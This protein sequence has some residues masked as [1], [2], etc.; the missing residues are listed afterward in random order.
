MIQ[1]KSGMVLKYTR[2]EWRTKAF[3]YSEKEVVLNYLRISKRLQTKKSN[4]KTA[5]IDNIYNSVLRKLIYIYGFFSTLQELTTRYGRKAADAKEISSQLALVNDY[6]IIEKKGTFISKKIGLFDYVKAGITNVTTG[7][8]LKYG[9]LR[10][11]SDDIKKYFIE[12]QDFITVTDGDGNKYI[13]NEFYADAP[14][15][16]IDNSC[17]DSG[18]VFV[19]D[20]TIES[21]DIETL[22]IALYQA[23]AIQQH[24][25]HLGVGHIIPTYAYTLLK[26]VKLDMNMKE[27]IMIKT[28]LEYGD[29]IRNVTDGFGKVALFNKDGNN[30]FGLDDKEVDMFISHLGDLYPMLHE[31]LLEKQTIKLEMS[32]KVYIAYRQVIM[33][34]MCCIDLV[35]LPSYMQM[36]S[37]KC[38]NF[39]TNYAYTLTYHHNKSHYNILYGQSYVSKN[40][41]TVAGY[42]LVNQVHYSMQEQRNIDNQFIKDLKATVPEG[43]DQYICNPHA[44]IPFF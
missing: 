41:N 19:N 2:D 40:L 6:E 35:F 23:L 8:Y 9:E 21:Q 24:I 4:R 27:N 5:V 43:E 33:R 17:E 30:T 16:R 36:S 13:T 34:Y 38:I 18:K 39:I 1:Y 32:K 3:S 28:L 22:S 29:D 25:S 15:I 14:V 31:N 11:T 20:K 10:S 42:V 26:N 12:C 44:Y 7:G 37:D